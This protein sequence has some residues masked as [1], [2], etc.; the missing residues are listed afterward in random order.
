MSLSGVNIL[1]L[2]GADI[3]RVLAVARFDLSWVGD[4]KESPPWQSGSPPSFL[5]AG[6]AELMSWPGS[7]DNCLSLVEGSSNQILLLDP[8]NL[9][10]QTLFVRPPPLQLSV[11]DRPCSGQSSRA[12]FTCGRQ[13]S[14]TDNRHMATTARTHAHTH[15]HTH[16][17]SK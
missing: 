11:S 2:P 3:D 9:F 17:R 10:P 14:N 7:K 4:A 1:Y 8:S 16:W 6:L 5:H 13:S 12:K 15:T